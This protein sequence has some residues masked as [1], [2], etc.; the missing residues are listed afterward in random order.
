MT[1]RNLFLSTKPF[2]YLFLFLVTLFMLTANP[3][4][5]QTIAPMDLLVKY[6]GWQNTQIKLPHIHGER[7]DILD[8]RLPVWIAAKRELHKGEM[9]LWLHERDKPGFLFTNSL[10]TPAFLTFTLVKDDALGFYLSNLL[11]VLIGLFGMFLF[12]RLF[13]NTYA[14][15]FG[16]IVFMFSGFNSAWF[17]WPHVNTAIWTPWVFFTIYRYLETDNKVYLPLIALSMFMINVAG[18]PMI[19]VMTYMAV[20]IMIIIFF[21]TQKYTF[22]NIIQTVLWL[23]LFSFLSILLA[24]PFLYPLVEL[25]SWMGGLGS[26]HGGN[27]FHLHD[28]QLFV[29]PDLYRYPRVESTFYV[30]ILPIMFLPLSLIMLWFKPRFILIFGLTLFVYSITIAFTLISPDIIHK[31]PTL[32]SSLLTRFGYLIDVSLAIISAFMIHTLYTFI[33]NKKWLLIFIPLLLAIQILDQKHLFSRFNGP[34]PNA[35]FYPQTKSISYLQKEFTLFNHVL[36]DSGYLIAGTL[37]GYGLNNW[38]SHSFHSG[39]EKEILR[40]LVYKPFRTPTSAMFSLPQ[41]QLDSPYMDYLGI[42]AILT[43][44]FAQNLHI[45]L[46]DNSRPQ[47][48]SP[49]LPVNTLKQ[50][51]EITQE[52]HT[53]GI[54]LQMAT[55]GQKHAS[56][57]VKLTLKRNET[58]V[59]TIIVDKTHIKDNEWIF[60]PFSYERKLIIGHYSI[61]LNMLDTRN[62][63]PLTVWSNKEERNYP[64]LVN[65]EATTL[66]FKMALTQENKLNDKFKILHLEP[67]IAVIENKHVKNGAYFIKALETNQSISY[68]SVSSSKR[69]NTEIQIEYKDDMQGYIVLPMR[70]YPGWAATLNGKT[71]PIQTFIEIL[72]AIKVNGKSTILLKYSPAY[73]IYTYALAIFSILI[74]LFSF[75]KFRKKD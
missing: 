74:L 17:F 48:P 36:T 2:P 42:K 11:N 28:F 57:D 64:L 43:T 72:P 8:G 31:I 24:L 62:A 13:L 15:L 58:I 30:G 39:K 26:R 66:S 10:L 5:S 51:F 53:T 23:A 20:A 63:T 33:S 9:P 60:F 61:T 12:L 56:S 45:D 52:I 27:G 46:W 40:K 41:I 14:S 7:S 4:K 50:P 25:L 69:S 47:V 37:G 21:I 22:K 32:N 65:N 16:A 44:T 75:L 19:A 18:F 70:K 73:N 71:V 38:F 68:E 6:P 29:N 1:I 34:V 67:H 55:Y 49:N 3:F 35:A 54:T 59:E